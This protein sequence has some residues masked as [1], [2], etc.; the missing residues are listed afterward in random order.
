MIQV[1]MQETRVEAKPS[2]VTDE[3]VNSLIEVVD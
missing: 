3:S 1:D 2:A